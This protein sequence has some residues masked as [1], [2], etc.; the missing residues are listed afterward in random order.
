[1]IIPL[2]RG[3]HLHLHLHFIQSKYFTQGYY[4]YTES[5]QFTQGYLLPLHKGFTRYTGIY[6][7]TQRIYN[8][9][10]NLQIV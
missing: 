4:L 10:V 3:Y 2:H 1:V 8:L 5:L 9:H 7:F 6:P